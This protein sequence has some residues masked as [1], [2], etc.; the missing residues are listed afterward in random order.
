M[1]TVNRKKHDF[2]KMPIDWNTAIRDSAECSF[3]VS[4]LLRLKVAA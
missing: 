1:A 2:L 3:A 4:N